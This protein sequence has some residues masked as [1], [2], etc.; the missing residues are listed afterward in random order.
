[1]PS[2][3]FYSGYD[4]EIVWGVMPSSYGG[5]KLY[6]PIDFSAPHEVNEVTFLV[7]TTGSKDLKRSVPKGITGVEKFLR[8]PPP[9][10]FILV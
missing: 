3:V 1:M 7:Y 5:Y 8:K 6:D 9:F 4:D 10:F 2:K